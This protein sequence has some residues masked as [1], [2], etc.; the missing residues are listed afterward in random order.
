MP[1]W[2][3]ANGVSAA[4]AE[5]YRTPGKHALSQPSYEGTYQPIKE[6]QL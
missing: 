2:D 4:F 6:I 3:R 5:S 1:A